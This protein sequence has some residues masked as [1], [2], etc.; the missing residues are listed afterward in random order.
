MMKQLIISFL[1]LTCGA[2]S[3]QDTI[4]KR[5]GELISAKISEISS[6]EVKYKRFTMQ[7][8]PLYIIARDEVKK[9]KFSNGTID[10][11][12]V[13]QPV[14]ATQPNVI[15]QQPTIIVQR[16][17]EPQK[18]G[19]IQNPGPGAYYYGQARI[20]EKSLLLL[21]TDKNRTWRNK[22]LTNAIMATR[23]YKSNQYIAGF[24]GAGLALICL[25][26]GGQSTQN[27][28]NGTIASALV[29][30][31]LGIFITSQIITPMFKR[32]RTQSARKVVSLYNQQL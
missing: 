16:A 30:N 17:M 11:F 8:G 13:S 25:I 4:Y 23:D 12:S 31:G 5:S 26:A 27:N 2:I 24:G 7:D 9:I 18:K 6:T 32:K 14:V 22:D 15:A 21:A 1:L 10:S 28:S 20:N 29:F 3:A 19:M